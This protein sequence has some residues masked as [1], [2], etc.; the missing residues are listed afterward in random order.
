LTTSYLANHFN[1]RT[2]DDPRVKYFSIAGRLPSVN[3]LHPFWLPKMVLDS[4]EEK[5]RR[6]LKEEWERE[7]SG[8]LGGAKPLWAHE[9]EWGND[10]L[11]PVQS[12]KWGEFLGSMEG[13]DHWEMRGARGIAGDLNV[14]MSVA[15]VLGLK[16]WTRFV[17]AFKKEERRE[18]EAKS[19][20][21]DRPSREDLEMRKAEDKL[22]PDI[23][24]STDKLSAVF[25]WM[26]EQVPAP[27][28]LRGL[29]LSQETK[30]KRRNEL[31]SKMDL[32][33]FYVAL[34]RKLYDEGL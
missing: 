2:P 13:C 18:S 31:A 27:S 30:D 32:E 34:S 11:V 7:G 29:S 6:R 17:G 24:S 23:K 26:V 33:R 20:P 12:A 10:G 22:D 3:I 8:N 4:T 5:E 19:R 28:R 1:P 21:P 15:D 25:D 14:D 16:D 9:E